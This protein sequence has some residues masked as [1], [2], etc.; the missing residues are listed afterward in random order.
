MSDQPPKQDAKVR[1]EFAAMRRAMLRGFSRHEPTFSSEELAAL[2]RGE[3]TELYTEEELA[4][5]LA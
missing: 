3:G 5:L 2:R 1:G 4:C